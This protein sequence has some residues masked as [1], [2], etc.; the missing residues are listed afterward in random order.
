MGQRVA[1]LDCITCKRIA[2][3]VGSQ[4]QH[5]LG[6]SMFRVATPRAYIAE[7]VACIMES[8]ARRWFLRVR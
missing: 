1:T 8:M 2:G 7:R 5:R 3:A 4:L 6:W